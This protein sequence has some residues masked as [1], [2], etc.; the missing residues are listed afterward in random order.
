MFVESDLN[1]FSLG[2]HCDGTK[3]QILDGEKTKWKYK[4]INV[5][6]QGTF[7]VV[8]LS[9]DKN[10]RRVAVKK[11]RI[12]PN[13]KN[14]EL[15]IMQKVHCQNCLALLD[16]YFEDDANTSEKYLFLVTDVYPY[17]LGKLMDEFHC[18][19]K[20]IDPFDIKLYA[21]QIFNGL[22]GMHWQVIAHRDIKPDNILIDHDKGVLQ[23]CDFGS[24]KCLNDDVIHISEIGS[25]YYR[26]PELLLNNRKYGVEIDIW[27]AGCVIAEMSLDN[28]AL[29]QGD[30][31]ED[32]LI[33]IMKV[34]GPPS[35]EDSN[36][37]EHEIPF[38]DVEQIADLS[39]ALPSSV[40]HELLDLLRRIFV[41]NPKQ[42]PTCQQCIDSPYFD[43]LFSSSAKRRNGKAL[44]ILF[45]NKNT[46]A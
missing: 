7:G 16:F 28:Y 32:Q 25:R 3:S 24:A 36:S 34:I 20:P 45:R 40:D 11:V 21:F 6:G 8:F 41:Y 19:S 30:S 42:R 31:N 9:F 38:P 35:Q 29:F 44:P 27:S 17:S 23:L 33:Q 39:I 12:D 4:V 13:F 18:L 10:Y 26:A 1:R 46:V 37:F 22:R 43:E 5:I 14:R 2:L 15:E